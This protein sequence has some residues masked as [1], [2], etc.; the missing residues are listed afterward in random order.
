MLLSDALSVLGRIPQ[1]PAQ[2]KPVGGHSCSK[3]ESS[4]T[5]R[6]A[7]PRQ[8]CPRQGKSTAQ[9]TAYHPKATPLRGPEAMYAATHSG[10]V[11]SIQEL[12]A[13]QPSPARLPK[14]AS[15]CP[16][17]QSANTLAPSAYIPPSL[18]LPPINPSPPTS[19]AASYRRRFEPLLGEVI[20][21]FMN[22][23]CI[24]A[25]W[26]HDTLSHTE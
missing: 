17:S 25:V 14:G 12:T 8:G 20:K 3:M 15:Y 9:L 26:D 2:C 4:T 6:V 1:H 13:G 21:P 5:S 23:S 24:A 16:A 7:T 22:P 18:T 10:L 11:G 19:V